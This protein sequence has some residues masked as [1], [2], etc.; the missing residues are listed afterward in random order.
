MKQ[1]ININF[2]GRVV[3]I[4]VSAFDQL[5]E[6]TDSLNRY[7]EG[8]EGREEIIND[9][10]SR[11]GEL[12]QERLKAGA[13]CITDE[14]V[15]AII[16]NMGRPEDFETDSAAAEA[17]NNNNTKANP[18]ENFYQFSQQGRNKKLYR[19]ENDKILGGVCSGLAHYF[20]I[21]VTIVRIIFVILAISFGFGI[22]PYL[23]LWIAVPSSA[24]M[25]IGG[26]RKKLYRDNDDKIIAGVCSGLGNYF[27]INPW[28][29][30][31]LFVLPLLSF[32]A[33][34]H[35]FHFV[36]FA[37]SP[38][39]V[40]IYI[41]LWLVLPEA[42]TT[43]EKLEM[44][45][46]K[47]DMNSIKNSI[48]GEMK[49][50][51]DRAQ[52]FGKEAK[53]FAQEK[54]GTMGADITAAAR[55]GSRS[56]GDII[57]LLF[58]IF[59]YFIL[60]CLGFALVAALFAL[61]VFAIGIFPMKDF[62][63]T[64]GWQN[65][66]AWGTLIFFIAVPIIGILTWI[67]RRITKMR[68]NSR[69]ING[70]F[71]ALWTLGWICFFGLLSFLG[72]D[73]H[74]SNHYQEQE[75]YLDSPTVNKLEVTSLT[76]GSKFFN[77]RWLRFEPFDGISE[78]DTLF[79][80]NIEVQLVKSPNDSFRVTMLKLARGASKRY[81]DTLAAK[82]NVN[83]YQQ[84]SLLILDRGI[85]INKTDKFRNQR[86]VL[87]IYV[88]VGKKVRVDHSIGWANN[89]RFSGPWR[90]DWDIDFEDVER[91]WDVDKEYIMKA[92]GLYDLNGRPAGRSDDWQSGY[93]PM[94]T[95]DQNGVQKDA[96]GNVITVEGDG[97]RYPGKNSKPADS[98][99]KPPVPPQAPELQKI[100]D[101]LKK[102]KDKIDKQL[103]IMGANKTE[104]SAVV[105]YRIA[106]YDPLMMR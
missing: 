13:T 39:S 84:D 11:I 22:I 77:N 71:I 60:G 82:I 19:D 101:S 86:V 18:G 58:K 1:V 45:G 96:N 27:G 30:R 10:E 32:A 26:L 65:I 105:T 43:S 41:I 83:I 81:A 33:N 3:P 40:I 49:D 29:P 56:L 21:D 57:A 59:L 16:R 87:T 95:E 73:F 17:A 42:L 78:D 8:E 70:S 80:K 64:S 61:A 23:V 31:V 85:A 25:E 34:W 46:E 2:H 6:Y 4:E 76:P 51:Q 106:G 37:F 12:F 91:G 53:T 24:T 92:D 94:N 14:D 102:E 66:L 20:N 75:V 47:V 89:V 36:R 7:F 5:K 68:R 15:Q 54:S 63:L 98:V 48:V 35:D 88:P 104:S 100:K 50:L 55:R 62:V 90:D 93:Q 67:I 44:K 72:R 69:M 74:S 99:A 79:V 38:G 9:I 28:I 52:K 97:Y 103:E